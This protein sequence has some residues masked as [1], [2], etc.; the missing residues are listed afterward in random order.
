MLDAGIVLNNHSASGGVVDFLYA[1][2]QVV[3]RPRVSVVSFEG[4]SNLANCQHNTLQLV[5]S[6][7]LE[8][9]YVAVLTSESASKKLNW[10]WP[11]PNDG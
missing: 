5:V 10:A 7:P 3:C 8:V 1:L 2:E 11:R 9:E 6:R 4:A